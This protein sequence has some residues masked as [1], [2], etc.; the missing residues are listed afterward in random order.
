[1]AH[2]LKDYLSVSPEVADA[3]KA[4][5]PVVALE[6]TLIAHGRPWPG[7]YEIATACEKAIRDNGALPATIGIID[8]IIRV[9]LTDDEI[10]RLAQEKNVRKA[11]RRDYGIAVARKECG[12]TTVAGTMI[13]AAMAG[14]K[15]FST[16]GI[17]GVHRGDAMDISADLQ[18]LAQTPVAVVCAGAKAI[19]D[20]PRT[21]EYLETMG[22]P[23]IGY[24]TDT[25]PG[26]FAVS[27]GLPVDTR[28]DNP[29]DIA[30][31]IRTHWDLGLPGGVLVTVPPPEELALSFE[32]V[33]SVVSTAAREAEE[34][35]VHGKGLTPFLLGRVTQMTGGRSREV[36]GAL[37]IKNAGAA[38]EIACAYAAL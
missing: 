15:V 27:S 24:K 33:D 10:K 23:V 20:Q 1:M 36:N 38:A 31:I 30:R 8:G 12:G 29:A 21:L 11:S 14:I 32:E 2:S 17:G 18:E 34:Q 28:S 37:L 3:L 13:G 26:F 25:F 4:G 5:K 19:L 16:G 35:G 22:V 9:G 7:N 6:S